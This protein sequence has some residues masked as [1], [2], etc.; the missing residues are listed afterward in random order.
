MVCRYVATGSFIRRYGDYIEDGTSLDAVVEMTLKDD[1]RG[2]PLITEDSLVA[3]GI[4]EAGAYETIKAAM[5]N[6]CAVIKSDLAERNLELLDI[7]L[8]FGKS[9][10]G[11]LMLMDEIS[12]GNMRVTKDKKALH[13]L[14]LAE[15]V[16]GTL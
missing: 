3:L 6:I 14:E 2:D 12:G 11:E 4:L 10:Q 9:K 5:K 7:K 13:P 1:D 15:I 8:E 16:L